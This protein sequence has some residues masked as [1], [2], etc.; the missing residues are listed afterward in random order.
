[1]VTLSF[2]KVE[3]MAAC[4]VGRMSLYIHSIL[5]DLDVSQ[6]AATIAYKDNDGCTAM[7]NAQKPTAR[8]WHI[9][10]KYFALC[11]WIEHNLIHLKRIDNSINIADHFTKPNSRILFHCHADFLLGHVPPKYSLVYQHANTTY[12][13]HFDVDINLFLPK[14]FMTP[15]TAKAAWIL[16][17]LHKDV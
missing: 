4:D 9:N 12:R 11:D 5:W 6:E 2:T 7:G 17:P 1:M 16:T 8:T 3:F 10:I 15:M 14:S 13:D